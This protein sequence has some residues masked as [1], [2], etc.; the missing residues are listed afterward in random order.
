MHWQVLYIERNG[1]VVIPYA[2]LP[3]SEVELDKL[4]A[5]TRMVLEDQAA[6]GPMMGR[7]WGPEQERYRFFEKGKR[8]IEELEAEGLGRFEWKHH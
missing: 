7:K 3:R 5:T 1:D 4:L 2:E 6:K 8:N